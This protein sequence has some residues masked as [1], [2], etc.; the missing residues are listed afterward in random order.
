MLFIIFA[1]GAMASSRT[2]PTRPTTSVTRPT[3]IPP[4]PAPE[5]SCFSLLAIKS[6]WAG[7]VPSTKLCRNGSVPQCVS[8]K[9]TFLDG[10]RNVSLTKCP[11]CLPMSLLYDLCKTKPARCAPDV[12]VSPTRGSVDGE[13]SLCPSCIPDYKPPTTNCDADLVRGCMLRLRKGEIARPRVCAEGEKPLKKDCCFSCVPAALDCVKADFEMCKRNFTKKSKCASSSKYSS[14]FGT[15][16]CRSCKPGVSDKRPTPKDKCSKA[17]FRA[18]L[19]KV[20]VCEPRERAITRTDILSCAPS[21]R[22]PQSAHPIKDVIECVKDLKRCDV[23]DDDVVLPGDRCPRCIAP[24]PACEPACSSNQ[25]CVYRRLNP[26]VRTKVC[27]A[28]RKFRLKLKLKTA[29]RAKI[30]SLDKK[31]VVR[32]IMEFVERFCE[33]NSQADRCDK[34]KEHIRDSLKCNKRT[35]TTDGVELE[36]DVADDRTLSGR[37]LLQTTTTDGAD[38]LVKD[39]LADDT[40]NVD[41]A[42]TFLYP[43]ES[44]ANSLS[45]GLIAMFVSL[46][47]FK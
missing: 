28:P 11:S 33:R 45:V 13:F 29:I 20:S 39:S 30:Q 25:R 1:L 27:V 9:T 4:R 21:C 5:T 24:K 18:A 12:M 38:V 46:M 8:K 19:E 17:D 32:A 42:T 7:N 40:D 10:L 36:L 2:S 22:R 47:I 23:E 35:N 16:C 3:R 34:F 43:F 14:K 15:D 41:G 26:H 37:R 6:C 44:S 31:Q